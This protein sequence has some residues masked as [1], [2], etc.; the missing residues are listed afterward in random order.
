MNTQALRKIAV[1]S[2]AVLIS[3]LS[4]AQAV[5]ENMML[6]IQKMQN[7]MATID[8]SKIQQLEQSATKL[9]EDVRDLCAAGD[10]ELAQEKAMAFGNQVAASETVKQVA[11]CA[12]IMKG[13]IPELSIA[14]FERDFSTINICDASL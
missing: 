8:M 2:C 6:K 10:V 12:E 14:D 13:M 1:L 5:P 4:H 3:A 11:R 7:C 9:R